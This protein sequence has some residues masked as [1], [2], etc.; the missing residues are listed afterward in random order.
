MHPGFFFNPSV[1]ASAFIN[2]VHVKMRYRSGPVFQSEKKC[3]LR[4]V[5]P[6]AHRKSTSHF[7]QLIEHIWKCAN[8]EDKSESGMEI[9]KCT[10]THTASGSSNQ[11]MI[12]KALM[13]ANLVQLRKANVE[14]IAFSMPHY[15][16]V[17]PIMLGKDPGGLSKVWI[18]RS[19]AEFPT[20]SAHW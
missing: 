10:G 17:P 13:K 19:C 8:C 18:A 16:S 4:R 9:S 3:L 14:F 20:A 5:V 15:W 7:C 2:L 11:G 12:M 1:F 6:P